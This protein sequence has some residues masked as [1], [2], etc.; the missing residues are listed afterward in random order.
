[1][2]K[3]PLAV[4]SILLVAGSLVATVSPAQQR[5]SPP[6]QP[7]FDPPVRLA[8]ID[9]FDGPVTFRARDGQPRTVRVVVRNWTIPNRQQ[10]ARFPEEGFLIVQLR[11]GQLT[12]V[13]A[14]QRQERKED[15]YWT[16]PAGVSMSIE[17]GND[18]ATIQTTAVR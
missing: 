8:P 7:P 15:E 12:T 13:I 4:L 6:S 9:R 5:P 14:G 3:R 1:M 2:S 11:G 18:T 10:I 16:V 17:T